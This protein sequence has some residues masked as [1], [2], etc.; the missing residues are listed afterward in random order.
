MLRRAIKPVT[1]LVMGAVPAVL[2][3]VEV[4]AVF[5][6]AAALGLSQTGSLQ[7]GSHVECQKTEQN[8]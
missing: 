6:V 2:A 7:L 4:D 1:G 5:A 8:H 3:V